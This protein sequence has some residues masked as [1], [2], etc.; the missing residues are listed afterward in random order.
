MTGGRMGHGRFVRPERSAEGAK[1]KGAR[2]NVADAPFDSAQDERVLVRMPLRLA[3]FFAIQ[4]V[5]ISP[6]AA[7]QRTYINP[8]DVDYRYN[9]EAFDESGVS[10]LS[11][12]VPIR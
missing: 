10:K 5:P 12:V 9:F 8:L 3:A 1:S 6:A 2:T 7:H 11:R 4:F